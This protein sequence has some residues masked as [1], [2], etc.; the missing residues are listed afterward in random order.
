M[1]QA[2]ITITGDKKKKTAQILLE[3]ELVLGSLHKIREELVETVSQYSTIHVTLNNV[4]GID[5]TGIQLLIAIKNRLET[6]HKNFSFDIQLNNEL[7]TVITQA[8]FSAL[9]VMLQP[10]QVVPV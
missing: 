9:P 2:L 10:G 1:K 8:G 7:N 4:T 5:L 3:G 6:L